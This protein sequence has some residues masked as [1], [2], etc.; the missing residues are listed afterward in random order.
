MLRFDFI[1]M[2]IGYLVYVAVFWLADGFAD[3]FNFLNWTIFFKLSLILIPSYIWTLWNMK[4]KLIPMD[5]CTVYIPFFFWIIF[6][7]IVGGKSATNF[8]V[9]ELPVVAILSG[10]YL[11]KVPIMSLFKIKNHLLMS[12]SLW[13]VVCFLIV[14]VHYSIPSLPT[15]LL[16]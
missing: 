5:Y 4:A 15:P 8:L 13:V 14:V 9:V 12:I 1:V 10:L 2:I 6:T 7:G 3:F 16:K 11:L